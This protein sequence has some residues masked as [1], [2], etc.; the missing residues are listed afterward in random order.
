MNRLV[1]LLALAI[2]VSGPASAG[3]INP[4]GNPELNTNVVAGQV[5]STGVVERGS[6][7][8]VHIFG[9]FYKIKFDRRYFPSGCAAL[10]ASPTTEP[11]VPIATQNQCGDVFT[12]SLYDASTGKLAYGEFQFIARED[13]PQHP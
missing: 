1:T 11:L 3:I 6:G 5:G 2:G 10:V 9:L 12:V 4:Y 7:F 13:A 8:R